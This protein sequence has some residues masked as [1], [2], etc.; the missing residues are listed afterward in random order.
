MGNRRLVTGACPCNGW[1]PGP[2]RAA[3]R[4]P[5]VVDS[6]QCCVSGLVGCV[7]CADREQELARVLRSRTDVP[8]G[9]AHR[10]C[11]GGS[12]GRAPR[13]RRCEPP[14]TSRRYCGCAYA[15]GVVISL[16]V[17]LH[18]AHFP[19]LCCGILGAAISLCGWLHHAHLSLVIYPA[20]TT[21]TATTAATAAAA[22]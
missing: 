21:A 12:T 5:R 11:H 9:T 22:G 18:H 14:L 10:C 19:R 7:G 15:V 1:F 2:A 6:A 16:C 13:R 4:P 20:A 17:W 8:I 3:P